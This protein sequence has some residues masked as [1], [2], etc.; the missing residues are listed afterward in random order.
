[1]VRGG[2]FALQ[3]HQEVQ[4]IEHPLVTG[5]AAFVAGDH[6]SVGHHGDAVDVALDGHR[7]KGVASRHLVAVAVKADRLVIVDL[8]GLEH[9]G[10]EGAF[11]HGHGSG[12][13]P[14]E[15]DRDR[16][17]VVTAGAPTGP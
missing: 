5:V 12:A 7:A 8:H 17:G 1:V 9:T 14:L 11:G 6:L 2:G 10:V 16:L 4:R 15:A 3:A 13:V